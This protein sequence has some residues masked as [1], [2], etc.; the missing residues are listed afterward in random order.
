MGERERER[1]RITIRERGRFPLF[2]LTVPDGLGMVR[3]M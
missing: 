1:K 2:F 3:M